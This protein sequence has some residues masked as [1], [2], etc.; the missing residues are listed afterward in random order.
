VTHLNAA[1]QWFK[2]SLLWRLR[3]WGLDKSCTAAEGNLIIIDDDRGGGGGD[4]SGGVKSQNVPLI[5]H[6]ACAAL[7]GFLFLFF[8]KWFG[9][10]SLSLNK[11]R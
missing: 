4:G 3:C 9:Y 7:L 11:M 5:K 6:A 10:T 1:S 2:L 8:T